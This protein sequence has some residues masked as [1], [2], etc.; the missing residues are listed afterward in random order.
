VQ[1]D[2][3]P[4]AAVSVTSRLRA[5]LDWQVR[6]STSGRL[7]LFPQLQTATAGTTVGLG[8]ESWLELPASGGR[9]HVCLPLS[10]VA[11]NPSVAWPLML[12]FVLAV[13][14]APK[15]LR[16]I[17][18]TESFRF[19]ATPDTFGVYA[20]TDGQR[21]E[22]EELS[23]ILGHAA[24]LRAG[25]RRCADVDADL[26]EVLGPAHRR[27][28]RLNENVTTEVRTRLLE[29]LIADGQKTP[30]SAASFI[31]QLESGMQRTIESM[32]ET[33]L[34]SLCESMPMMLTSSFSK[35]EILFEAPLR[36]MRSRTPTD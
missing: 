13:E 6:G 35:L 34:R 20:G 8:P 10:S 33:T 19:N 26:G 25:T 14:V 1:V 21:S 27:W 24:M 15:V 29:R 3:A 36:R 31:E 17:A 22:I 2:P 23:Q 4:G 32:D 7:L 16:P 11:R 30:D 12:H 5:T 9:V 18:A 28:E